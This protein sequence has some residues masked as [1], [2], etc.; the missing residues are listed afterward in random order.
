MTQTFAHLC[1][2]LQRV[3]IAIKP[4]TQPQWIHDKTPRLCF[5]TVFYESDPMLW[6]Q[7]TLLDR[8]SLLFSEAIRSCTTCTPISDDLSQTSNSRS[9]LCQSVIPISSVLTIKLRN[10]GFQRRQEQR[11]RQTVLGRN[12]S[13]RLTGIPLGLVVVR[14]LTASLRAVSTSNSPAAVPE[15]K[16]F[17]FKCSTA[18]WLN[19]PNVLCVLWITMSA[20]IDNPSATS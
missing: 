2:D 3:A 19:A 18:H 1:I 8:L 10:A 11:C 13:H 15:N 20:P 17:L 12:R 5:Q 16:L 4:Q 14:Q 6:Q 9:S 7:T